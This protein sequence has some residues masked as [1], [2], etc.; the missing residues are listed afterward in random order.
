M[1]LKHYFE[2]DEGLEEA[3]GGQY[4]ARLAGSA[5]TVINASIMGG[6]STTWHCGARWSP[7]A[8]RW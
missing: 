2:R 4:L 6:R 5:V 1:T 7:S 8:R 3:G